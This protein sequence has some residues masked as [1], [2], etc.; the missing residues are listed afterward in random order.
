MTSADQTLWISASVAFYCVVAIVISL[1]IYFVKRAT[2]ID[3]IVHFILFLSLFTLPLPIRLIFTDEIEGNISPYLDSFSGYIPISVFFC[4]CSLI[5]FYMSYYS[6]LPLRLS[7]Y[8][9][10]FLTTS[11]AGAIFSAGII[12]GISL[13]LLSALAANIGGL[14]QFILLGYASTKETVGLG[15]LAAGLPWL[16]VGTMFIFVAYAISRRK[17]WFLI[18]SIAL[19]AN[20]GVHLVMGNRSM[21]LYILICFGTFFLV[22]IKYLRW[23]TLLVLGVAAFVF[24]NIVGMTRKSDYHSFDDFVTKSLDRGSS[25]LTSTG[26][27]MFYTLTIGEFVVPF[28]TLPQMVRTVGTEIEPWLGWSYI[29]APIFFVPSAVFPDRPVDL[30]N[31]YMEQFYKTQGHL[32]EGRQ[33]FFLAEAYLNFGPLGIVIISIFWGIGWRTWFEWLKRSQF[34][35]GATLLYALALGFMFRCISGTFVTLLSGLIQQ[36]LAIALIGLIISGTSFRIS[37]EGFSGRP[38]R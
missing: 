3:P 7:E 11:A 30:A 27:G 5:I 17:L 22:Q 19:L 35:P 16:F 13:L 18:G 4:A 28:E 26:H 14:A 20:I 34:D 24:L 8:G 37:A 9:F 6:R 32:N 21:V 31:W 1:K 15:Y 10:R 33:F 29:R 38:A 2:L 36:S 25:A 12:I 23:K